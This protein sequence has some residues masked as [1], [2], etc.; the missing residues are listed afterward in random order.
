MDF[1]LKEEL[2]KLDTKFNNLDKLK[3]GDKLYYENENIMILENSYFQSIT[4]LLYFQD[5]HTFYNKFKKD[6]NRLNKIF[7]SL[8][9]KTI[10]NTNS[11]ILNTNNIV[12]NNDYYVQINFIHNKII[13]AINILK[14]TYEDD[15]DYLI[16]LDNL[17]NSIKF[18]YNKDKNI[19][20]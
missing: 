7:S 3:K 2:T 16:K 12:L 15:V 9:F 19:L 18:F 20:N 11:I 8:L 6:I 5:R 1:L 10:N 4:R 14:K 17:K 13:K